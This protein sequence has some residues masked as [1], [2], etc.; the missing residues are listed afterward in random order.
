MIFSPV[1]CA[2]HIKIVETEHHRIGPDAFD[3]GTRVSHPVLPPA[4]KHVKICA[5]IANKLAVAGHGQGVR[6]NTKE[7][8]IFHCCPVVITP[9]I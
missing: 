7:R 9:E 1:N 4:I 2:A 3:V 5:N 6:A 8:V